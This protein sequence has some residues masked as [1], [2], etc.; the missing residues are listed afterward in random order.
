MRTLVLVLVMLAGHAAMAET[1]EAELTGRL[2]KAAPARVLFVGNSY[3]FQVPKV[4]A[5]LAQSEG[6]KIVVEQVTKGGWTLARHAKAEATLA[7][8]RDGGWD[9]VVLQE[10]SQT[11]AFPKAQR[12]RGMI[13]AAK[14]LV[15]EI[16]KAGAV[17]AMFVTWGRRDGDQQNAKIFPGDTMEAM[18]V[19]LETGYRE[20]ADEAGGA[21]L[22]PVGP[23]WLKAR[24]A[25]KMDGLFAKDGSHPA[26]DGVYLSACVFYV[27]FYDTGVRKARGREKELAEIAAGVG[28]GATN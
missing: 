18:Q 10:Q 19:R 8:I 6:R 3:S 22:V 27:T 26:K 13:P 5:N 23:T 15:A 2:Q 16:R 12:E 14:A 20:A 11:P 9:V 17:P 21:V 28:I 4:L 25:G 24:N 7:R 1:L